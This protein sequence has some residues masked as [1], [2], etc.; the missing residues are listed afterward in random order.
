MKM[1]L[2]TI[3]QILAI[4]GSLMLLTCGILDA[5]MGGWKVLVL[6]IL[7]FFANIVIFFTK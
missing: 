3:K 4:I 2:E 5:K 1:E 6:G 7:Y